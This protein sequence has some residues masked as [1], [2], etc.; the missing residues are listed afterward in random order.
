MEKGR[1][2]VT[3]ASLVCGGN[4]APL[5]NGS[6]E[7]LLIGIRLAPAPVIVPCSCPAWNGDRILHATRETQSCA[8]VTRVVSQ[9]QQTVISG[10]PP[11]AKPGRA[12]AKLV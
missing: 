5:T 10:S 8:V 1:I 7:R 6:L 3:R 2:T 4:G 12:K 9:L 11:V